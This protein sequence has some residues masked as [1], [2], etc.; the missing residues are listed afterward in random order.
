MTQT[1]WKE[2]ALQKTGKARLALAVIGD[3]VDRI[4]NGYYTGT[5]QEHVDRINELFSRRPKSQPASDLF[6]EY[7]D[8]TEA[9]AEASSPEPVK[10]DDQDRSYVLSAAA[11]LTSARSD[12]AAVLANAGPLLAW[13]EAA[14]SRED[15]DIRVRAL[16]KQRGIDDRDDDDPDRFLAEAVKLYEFM[17]A[18]QEG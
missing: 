4:F 15:M 17:T 5:P 9:E 18:G 6:I 7:L 1:G 2:S 3:A 11:G 12:A 13:V 8:D 16:I 10:A 14:D